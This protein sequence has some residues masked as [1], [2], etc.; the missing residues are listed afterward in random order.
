MLARAA[1]DFEDAM[2][3]REIL[4]EHFQDGPLIALAGGRERFR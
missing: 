4:L 3:I 1:T 2:P